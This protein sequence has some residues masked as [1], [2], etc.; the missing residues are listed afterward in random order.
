MSKSLFIIIFFS[1]IIKPFSYS[2]IKG[3]TDTLAHNYNSSATINDGSCV[4]NNLKVKVQKSIDL[5]NEIKETSGLFFW[6]ELLW[7]HN[8]DKDNFIYGIDM[9]SGKIANKIQLKSLTNF[10]WEE[11]KQDEKYLYV[12]DIGNNFG[13]RKD[14]KIYKIKK[15]NLIEG[16]FIYDTI[17]FQY[18]LQKDIK[19]NKSNTTNFDCEAFIVLKDSIIFFTK[20][21]S[22]RKTSI[23][24]IPNQPGK[25]IA[26]FKTILD[27]KGLIT[28]ATYIENKNKIILC[29]YSKTLQPFLFLIYDFYNTNLNIA[30][31]RR[32]EIDLPFHQ[33][34]GV[35]F[36]NDKLFLTNE[37]FSKSIIET[38]NKLFSLT[39]DEF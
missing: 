18:S 5:P 39:M 21:W 13:N 30:N 12:G 3:C 15:E 10:D 31:K 32:I 4:Y 22:S 24:S 19:K 23:Y 36:A 9:V 14:L 1:L 25:H 37:K 28:G 2:Q 6:N 11:V 38:T 17:S 7:T 8:D 20:E 33:I 29:G 27:V 16:K 34:E 35:E 26:Q